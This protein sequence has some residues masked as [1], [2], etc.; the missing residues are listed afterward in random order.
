[1]SYKFSRHTVENRCT[2][3]VQEEL[4]GTGRK[5]LRRPRFISSLVFR[6]HPVS[7]Q[8]VSPWLTLTVSFCHKH[9]RQKSCPV[10]APRNVVRPLMEE[11]GHQK[12]LLG[13]RRVSGTEAVAV[14]S[15]GNKRHPCKVKRY[16]SGGDS[17]LLAQVY[18]FL[19]T[20]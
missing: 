3:E 9:E 17:F 7:L 1:M 16:R 8:A 4:R 11:R 14:A 12:G 5:T 18:K 19:S 2:R 10:L 20:N 13:G 15:A 6:G